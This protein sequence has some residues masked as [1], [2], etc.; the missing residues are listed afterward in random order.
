MTA[1][2][3]PPVSP[4][5]VC[6]CATAYLDMIASHAGRTGHAYTSAC[7]FDTCTHPISLVDG[8]PCRVLRAA[9]KKLLQVHRA[10]SLVLS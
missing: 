3:Q 1:C 10:T 2:A 4:S 7:F 8:N 5:G 9:K 6:A